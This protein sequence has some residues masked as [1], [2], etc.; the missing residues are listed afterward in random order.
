MNSEHGNVHHNHTPRRNLGA[1]QSFYPQKLILKFS[2]LEK[3]GG[4]Y[5]VIG[6]DVNMAQQ[7]AIF[8]SSHR[9]VQGLKYRWVTI[10]RPHR[11]SSWTSLLLHDFH[12][13]GR[14]ITG[15]VRSDIW[16]RPQLYAIQLQS[17][18]FTPSS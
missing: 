17:P 18:C 12:I 10:L 2:H 5:I 3:D 8:A 7:I 4:V 11:T 1:E 9:T 6:R 16:T 15:R 13:T 14:V